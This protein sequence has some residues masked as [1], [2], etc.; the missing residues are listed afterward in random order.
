MSTLPPERVYTYGTDWRQC[1]SDTGL[2]VTNITYW[3][4][5]NCPAAIATHVNTLP[6]GSIGFNAANRDQAKA[7]FT[8][9]MKKYDQSGYKITDNIYSP[10]F[11]PHQFSISSLCLDRSNGGVCEEYLSKEYC[12]QFTRDDAEK[13]AVVRSFCGCYVPPDASLLSVTKKE[14]C[15]PLC[16]INLTVQKYDSVGDP[17]VCDQN[18]CAIGNATIDIAETSSLGGPVTFTN[19]CPGCGGGDRDCACYVDTTDNNETLLKLG[20][21][22]INQFCG[23]NSICI[24][25]GKAAKCTNPILAKVESTQMRYPS[26]IFFIILFLILLTFI[27]VMLLLVSDASRKKR[28]WEDYNNNLSSGAYLNYTNTIKV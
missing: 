18:V 11:S 20:V 4:T 5:H 19:I 12:P 26:S 9:Y 23:E 22:Q 7:Q 13:N 27:L 8:R 2:G 10:Y 16:R 1:L 25:N 28:E 14:Q 21:V 6:D 24:T 15:D 3:Q 17:I